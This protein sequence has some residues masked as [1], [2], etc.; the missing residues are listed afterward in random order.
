MADE[1]KKVGIVFKADGSV[2]FQKTLKE[3]NQSINENRSAFKLAQ[4]EWDKSTSAV[5]KLRTRQE[6]LS[7]QTEA[8]GQKVK[9]LTDILKQQE[10]AENRDEAAISKTRE[11]LNNAQSSLNYYQ[12]GLEEVNNELESGTAKFQD[13]ADKVDAVGGKFESASKKMAGISAASAGLLTGTAKIAS[14]FEDAMAKVSTIAD[15]TVVSMDDMK[16]AIMELSNETGIASTDIAENVYN[17]IS[18]GQDTADAVNFVKNATTLA[19]AGFTDSAA[20][21]DLLTTALN[22]YGLEASEVTNIS[23]TLIMTQNLGKTSVNELASSMGKVIPTANANNVAFKQ[24]STAYAVMTA[25]GV[26]TA[27]ST[28]KINAML[29]E[30]GKT[31]T[32]VD[33]T[34]REKTGNSFSELMNKGMSLSDVLAIIK[35]SADEQKLAFGDLWSSTQ[36]GSAALTLLGDSADGFN[37]VLAEMENSSGATQTAFNKLDTTSTQVKIA[38]NELKNTGIELG[39]EALVSAKPVLEDICEMVKELSEWFSSLDDNQKKMIVT[40]ALVVAAISP[41][42]MVIGKVI[43]LVSTIITILPTLKAGIAAV[44][45]V[46]EANPV[47]AVIIVIEILIATIM[48]LYQNCEWFRDGVNKIG[49]EIA[50]LFTEKIPE[51]IDNVINWITDNWQGLLL[52]LV[53]PFVGGF[54]LLY[55]NCDA[56][57][58]FIDGWIDKIKEKIDNL[59]DKFKQIGTDIEEAWQAVK[60]AIKLPHFDIKGSFSITPPKTPKISVD[61]YAKGG[62]LNHPTIFGANGDTLMGGGEAGA[63]AVLPIKLLMEYMRNANAESNAQLIETLP[64]MIAEAVRQMP[65]EI[66]LYLGN[67]LLSEEMTDMVVKKMN[68]QNSNV[69]KF[70][71]AS[72]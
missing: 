19:K 17:A 45:A 29:A 55:D 11:Q 32:K 43:G 38:M 1:M 69:Q 22:A 34:L 42:L 51:K 18:A 30:L 46:L 60:D 31:G 62:I 41:V 6:Y 57:R 35:D 14:N 58:D 72:G 54:K 2:N 27:E 25:K 4:S 36:A 67:K 24:L 3:V 40:I 26:N 5:D 37:S 63:E 44:N 49:K 56:F 20:A 16:S 39:E 61:W 23:D 59:I 50:E 33:V 7:N 48:Y 13:Y 15:E 64:A 70:K 52:V 8:Y 10:E 21:T 47:L 66:A 71:G 9:E 68:K 65:V 53:N 12:Q 28:T